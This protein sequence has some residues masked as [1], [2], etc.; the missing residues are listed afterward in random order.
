MLL[1]D[2]YVIGDT[3][4]RATARSL[5]TPVLIKNSKVGEKDTVTSR[6]ETRK[7]NGTI[8]S[9]ATS[10]YSTLARIARDSSRP[11]GLSGKGGEQKTT[12]SPGF[13]LFTRIRKRTL[14]HCTTLLVNEEAERSHQVPG[15]INSIE[16]TFPCTRASELGCT[17]SLDSVSFPSWNLM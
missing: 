12:T 13:E 3:D 6:V 9:T 7:I 4:H 16:I 14:Y 8:L 17:N 10:N 2:H 5:L 11:R 15:R 1:V